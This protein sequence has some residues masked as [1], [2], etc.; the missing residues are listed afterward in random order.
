MHAR[1]S[2]PRWRVLVAVLL[3]GLLAGCRGAST[4]AAGETESPD[5]TT[6]AE[7]TADDQ[8]PTVERVSAQVRVEVSG[9]HTFV[10]EGKQD[11]L[12]TRAGRPGNAVNLLSGGFENPQPLDEDPRNRFRWAFDLREY[13]DAPGSFNLDGVVGGAGSSAF[14]IVMRVLDGSKLAVHD[15]AEVELFEQYQ[16]LDQPCT[17]EVGAGHRSGV[18]RCPALAE[19]EAEKTLS[20]SVTWSVP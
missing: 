11:I 5:D 14:V 8:A 13:Q 15:W 7:D 17:L 16:R 19:A 6:L 4:T 9:A 1:T 12:F 2:W 20:L 18:L 3:L 10:W